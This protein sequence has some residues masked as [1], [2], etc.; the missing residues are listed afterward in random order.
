M[1]G[2]KAYADALGKIMI[3]IASQWTMFRLSGWDLEKLGE[4]TEDE[5]SEK[6]AS[7]QNCQKEKAKAEEI[8]TAA[9]MFRGEISKY[10]ATPSQRLLG[11]VLYSPSISLSTGPQQFMEDWALVRVGSDRIDWSA[12]KGNVIYLGTFRSLVVCVYVVHLFIFLG[13]KISML[14]F[15]TKLCPHPQD[16]STAPFGGFLKIK[17]FLGEDEIRKPKQLDANGEECLLVIKSGLRTG[18]TVGRGSSILSFVRK[19]DEHGM[20]IT[21]MEIPVYSYSY[22]DRAFSA[23]GDSGS[24]VVDRVGRI[25]G[26]LTGGA[27]KADNIDVTYLTP[28]YWIEKEIKKV[29]P[30]SFLYGD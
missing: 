23:A 10:W 9:D 3:K 12:L 20:K 7:R 2:S 17:G 14:D 4:A 18:V 22:K 21:S 5:D 8:L 15:G 16:T 24:I 11:Y 30:D 29:F 19:R 6:A 1:L 28:Y 27:G 13:N 25:V 26:L